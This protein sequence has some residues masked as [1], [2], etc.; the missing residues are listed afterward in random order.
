MANSPVGQ[1]N[2]PYFSVI[3][4]HSGESTAVIPVGTPVVLQVNG[5]GSVG[6]GYS[7]VLPSSSNAGLAAALTMGIA[8]NPNSW[9]AGSYND[10]IV[11]GIAANAKI[12]LLTRSATNAN[13]A[14]FAAAAAGDLLTVD[15]VRNALAWSGTTP[16]GAQGMF[17]LMDSWASYTTIASQTADTTFTW[18][19]TLNTNFTVVTL[20][21]AST[22]AT[23]SARVFIRNID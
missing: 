5:V 3:S 6:D 17:N 16:A 12:L 1:K 23:V 10:V 4:Y 18:A 2:R 20:S 7:V 21:A 15:T 19:N 14:S 22:V 9:V 11:G 8:C 13:W